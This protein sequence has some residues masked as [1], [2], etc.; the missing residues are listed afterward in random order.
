VFQLAEVYDE[1]KRIVGQCSDPVFFRTATD[2]LSLIAN[3]LEPE[4]L[5]GYLDI[6]TTSCKCSGNCTTGSTCNNAACGRRCVTLP[7]E[8]ETILAVNI[9]GHPSLGMGELFSFHLNGPGDCKNSC[10]WS[11]EDQGGFHSTY[12]DLITPANLVAFLQTPE[13]NGKQLVVFGYDVNGNVLRHQVGGEWRNG[14]LIPTIFGVA[15]PDAE[16]PKV[17]RITGIFKEL[18][19]AQIRLSTTD[20]SGATGVTLGIYEPDETV[21]QYRRIRLNRCCNWVRIAY[22]KINPIFRSRYDHVPLKSRI[23]FLL[24]IAARK[25]YREFAL[26]EAH[27]FEADAMRLELEAQLTS[28]PPTYSP[29]QVIDMNNPRNKSDFDIR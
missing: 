19:V 12:R 25:H 23:A 22:R 29:P 16:Q 6:C 5:R 14:I 4:A 7:R 17:A 20:D 26:A 18:T 13:D 8:V 9:G 3:K 2:A 28:E 1:A 27:A 24:A 21:P 10:D 11:W 15:V